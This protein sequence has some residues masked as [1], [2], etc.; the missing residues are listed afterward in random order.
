MTI[1]EKL[2][3]N[4]KATFNQAINDLMDTSIPY[5]KIEKVIKVSG[6]YKAVAAG[7]KPVDYIYPPRTQDELLFD[8][9]KLITKYL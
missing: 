5:R 2:I 3:S 6:Q 1:I 7:E 8:L 9:N 4:D